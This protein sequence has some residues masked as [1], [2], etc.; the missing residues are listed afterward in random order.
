MS[1]SH[2]HLGEDYSL[3]TLTVPFVVQQ[4]TVSE[5]P[6]TQVQITLMTKPCC[7]FSYFDSLQLS[8]GCCL[9]SPLTGKCTLQNCLL[10]MDGFLP[11][12]FLEQ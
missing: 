9:P 7:I 10:G 1:A 12:L 2:F 5:S 3:L 6:M 8:Q 11:F 4:K